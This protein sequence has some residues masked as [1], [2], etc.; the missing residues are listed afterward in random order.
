LFGQRKRARRRTGGKD[1]KTRK[2]KVK[3]IKSR[4]RRGEGRRR[5]K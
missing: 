2:N 1:L 5:E 3:I 4:H